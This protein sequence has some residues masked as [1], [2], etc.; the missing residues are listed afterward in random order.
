LKRVLLK[1]NI[2]RIIAY[3]AIKKE[4]DLTGIC[5]FCQEKNIP[6]YFP[7]YNQDKEDYDFIMV[8]DIKSGF[9]VGKYGILEPKFSSP[10]LSLSDLN[11][12][13]TTWLIPGI[14]YDASGNRI[15][16]GKGYYDEFLN[17]VK[18]LKVGIAHSLQIYNGILPQNQADI[19]MD[20]VITD[21]EIMFKNP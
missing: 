15:G 3:S 9:E 20:L 5:Q 21:Q 16:Y 6:V 12:K 10:S 1:N 18:G 11:D 2:K 4:I 13:N 14:V 7:K 8:H 19:P 17:K